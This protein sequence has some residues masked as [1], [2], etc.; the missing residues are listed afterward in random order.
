MDIYVRRAERSDVP[1]MLPLLE[2]LDA[3]HRESYPERF[4]PHAEGGRTQHSLLKEMVEP[5]SEYWLAVRAGKVLGLAFMMHRQL[6]S[7]PLV[8]PDNYLLLDMLV[9]E[10]GQRRKGIG[11]MLVEQA[12]KRAG[13]EGYSRVVIKVYEK[14]QE[15]MKFY[16]ELGYKTLKRDL[17]LRLDG[18]EVE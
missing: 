6:E 16:E 9:V 11:K 2:Q 17:E 4:R 12:R 3:W 14:N 8:K 13:E 7:N 1:Q 5:S 10:E 15:A 18:I